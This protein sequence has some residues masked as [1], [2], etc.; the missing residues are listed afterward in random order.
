VNRS[1]LL[2]GR[3]GAAAFLC[4]HSIADPGPAFLSV[5]PA[6][7]ERQLALLRRRGYRGGSSDSLR[8]LLEGR[9]PVRRQA[10]LTFDDGYADTHATARPLLAE[11]GLRA[12]VFVLPPLLDAGAPLAWEG[13]EEHARRF[14][15]VQ[16]SMTWDQVEDLRA[17]GH[18]IGNHTLTHPHL[19][20][21][22]PEELRQELLDARRALQAR[23][24]RCDALAYP[25]GDWSPGV[26]RAARDTGHTFAFTIPRRGQGRGHRL[27]IPR[28]P[29]DHR[30]D[31]RRL[32]LKLSVPGRALLL[33]PLNRVRTSV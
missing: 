25:Y 20:R 16:R 30:D 7:F 4:Y 11:H 32:A 27:A 1:R 15:E 31:E 28:L 8:E 10:F 33:S 23:F 6:L 21:L 12:M 17:D 18:E 29:V 5:P 19:A 9:R 3:S 24:G 14:P 13:V 2:A 22:G 26:A